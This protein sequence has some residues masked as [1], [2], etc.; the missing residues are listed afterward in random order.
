MSGGVAPYAYSWKNASGVVSTSKVATGL[1]AG[2]YTLTVKDANNCPMTSSAVTVPEASVITGTPTGTNLTTPVSVD[3]KVTV[4]STAGGY[5]GA[6]YVYELRQ[7]AT[8]VAAYQSGTEFTG[9]AA[10]TYQ[11][12]VKNTKDA[13]TFNCE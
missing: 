4:T 11:V 1:A 6:G 5:T 9:L 13:M 8:V 3:G 10:G 7:G 2:D 12:W